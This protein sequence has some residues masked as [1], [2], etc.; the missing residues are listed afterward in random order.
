MKLAKTR[1]SMVQFH[2]SLDCLGAR[3]E[4]RTPTLLRE[5]DFES[6][7]SA[8]SAIR[9]GANRAAFSN[10]KRKWGQSAPALF[11]SVETECYNAPTQ[12]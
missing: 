1:A 12:T 10:M 5:P 11:S 6:G 8:S 7:A 3:R 4:G 2:Y 9:A